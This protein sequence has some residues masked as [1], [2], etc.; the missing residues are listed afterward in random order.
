MPKLKNHKAWVATLIVVLT[1]FFF[2]APSWCRLMFPPSLADVR[3][4][5]EKSPLV[6]R[7]HVIAVWPVATNTEPRA[8]KQF[9]ASIQV[10]RWYRG[11]GSA[12]ALLH[13]AYSGRI[14]ADGHDCIDFRPETYWIV[15]AKNEG[16][17]E[18]I[19]DCE[20]ALAVSPLLGPDLANVDWRAQ[21]EADF[22]AGL[23]DPDSESRLASIQRLGGLKLS[24]SR[25]ALHR[26]IQNG[27]DAGSKWAVYATLR[28]GDLTVLPLVRQIL[29][30][31]DRELPEWAIA[32]E[33]QSVTDPSAVPELIAILN[34][35]PGDVTRSRILVALGEKLRD[36]RAVPSLAAHLTDPDRYA[37]YD[38]LDGLKNITHE[39]ACTL[40]PGWK[41]QDIEPQ[42]AQ[43]KI[44]WEQSGKSRNWTQPEN[45][46]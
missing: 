30:K 6:F 19:D 38:A 7:G 26:V 41:E 33:L 43:C 12:P 11:S 8:N 42:I 5:A 21:M 46:R 27:D 2:A 45:V 23:N 18:P 29:A 35:A 3:D 31:G 44:W 40:P 37:R 39:P 13:F 32:M 34:S 22:L 1:I 28:T 20:G 17:L 10:D 16:Q 9:I 14:V 25:E 36:P 4:L 24:S 15:F